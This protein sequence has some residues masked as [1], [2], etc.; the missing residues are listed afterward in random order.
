[1]LQQIIKILPL[2]N[3]HNGY[4]NDTIY[5][6]DFPAPALQQHPQSSEATESHIPVGFGDLPEILKDRPQRFRQLGIHNT[7]YIYIVYIIYH[8]I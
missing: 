3:Q 8:N 2:C 6:D 5:F 1:M 4:G 7:Y